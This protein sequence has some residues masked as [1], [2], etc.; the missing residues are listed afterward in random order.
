MKNGAKVAIIVFVVVIVGIIIGLEVWL[1]LNR[2]GSSPQ[3]P[4]SNTHSQTGQLLITYFNT[5]HP[6]SSTSDLSALTDSELSSVWNMMC[7]YYLPLANEIPSNKFGPLYTLDENNWTQYYPADGTDCGSFETS[8]KEQVF[9]CSVFGSCDQAEFNSKGAEPY[10]CMMFIQPWARRQGAPNYA[11]LESVAFVCEL[12]GIQLMNAPSCGELP[13]SIDCP[14]KQKIREHFTSYKLCSPKKKPSPPR[15]PSPPYAIERGE[16]NLKRVEPQSVSPTSPQCPPVGSGPCSMGCSYSSSG[17]S[18]TCC[19]DWS[20]N[21]ANNEVCGWPNMCAAQLSENGSYVESNYCGV[22]NTFQCLSGKCQWSYYSQD[23][24]SWLQNL[25]YYDDWY[26]NLVY[27]VKPMMLSGGKPTST[28]A[29][30][31]FYSS[32]GST[33]FYW[34]PGYGKFINYGLTA[35][36]FNYPHFLLTCPKTTSD[37]KYQLRWSFPQVIQ[38]TVAGNDTAL[39]KQ[40]EDLTNGEW[41]DRREYLLGYVTTLRGSYYEGSGGS[42]VNNNMQWGSELMNVNGQFNPKD[43]SFLNWIDSTTITKYYDPSD[44]IPNPQYNKQVKFSPAEAVALVTG[45][46]IYGDNQA[47]WLGY[48]SDSPPERYTS[49]FGGWPF[50]SYFIGANLGT[51]VYSIGE[52]MGCDSLQFTYMPTGAGNTSYCNYPIYDFETVVYGSKTSLCQQFTM[53][54]ITKDLDNYVNYGFIQGTGSWEKDK[55]ILGAKQFDASK[56]PLTERNFPSCLDSNPPNAQY[57]D[58]PT[59]PIEV[60]WNCPYKDDTYRWIYDHEES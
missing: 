45:A 52:Q 59:P 31:S 18:N 44:K 32:S 47:Q 15:P 28:M 46:W 58:Q 40:L 8:G 17:E 1:W 41:Y 54:D 30:P 9:R 55:D 12:L 11:Y 26:N 23:W 27:D 2:G 24:F 48:Y 10:Q 4:P 37:G 7:W 53:L 13:P 36:Y 16:E 3:P 50:G 5:L 49:S 19:W 43:D 60:V 33:M 14:S 57:Y 38:A 29:T 56:M 35:V 51:A 39:Q 20:T 42:V 22:P 25:N 21:T 34:M 6:Q